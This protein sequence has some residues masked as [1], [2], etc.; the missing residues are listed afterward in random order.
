MLS[1]EPDKIPN[2]CWNITDAKRVWLCWSRTEGSV[3]HFID[4][5]IFQ[6][7]HEIS[8][9]ITAR[10]FLCVYHLHLQRSMMLR[11]WIMKLTNL[12]FSLIALSPFFQEMVG[13]GEPWGLHSMTTSRPFVTIIIFFSW[14][15]A[16]VGAEAIK[17]KMLVLPEAMT[18]TSN[19]R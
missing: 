19:A 13:F 17:R 3:N 14:F 9:T 18:I 6:S 4:K 8:F 7:V 12:L 2:W 11:V 1:S 5:T 15:S 16:K 10:L